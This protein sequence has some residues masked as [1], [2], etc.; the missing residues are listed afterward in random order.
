M[1]I[2]PENKHRYPPNWPEIS[3]EIKDRAGWRC[4]CEARVRP[5]R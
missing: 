2:R 3:R 5:K 4:E 1:P